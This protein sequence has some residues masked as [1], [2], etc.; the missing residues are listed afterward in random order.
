MK[1]KMVMVVLTLTVA[2]SSIL[3]GCGEAEETG[4]R[5]ER[6]EMT[7]QSEETRESE[8]SRES[9]GDSDNAENVVSGI[10]GLLGVSEPEADEPE[11]L[12]RPE[13]LA[14]TEWFEYEYDESGNLMLSGR[15]KGDASVRL[16]L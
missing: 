14:L 12:V 11:R 6:K 9:E 4:G 13:N 10:S 1:K 2:V 5:A 3:G 7:R 15:L 8:E 16:K